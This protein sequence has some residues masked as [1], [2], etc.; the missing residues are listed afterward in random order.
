MRFFC[1]L[2][3]EVKKYLGASGKIPSGGN[4]KAFNE[5]WVPGESS[6]KEITAAVCS[7]SGLCAWHLIDGRR[8]KNDTGAIK[9]GL[10]IIDVDNQDDK[11]DSDGEK[12]QRQE[13]TP[14]ES[15]TLDLSKKYLSLGYFSPSSTATWPRFRLVFGLE[16]PIIDPEFFQ[17]FTRFIAEQIPGSDRRATQIVNL[18]YGANPDEKNSI[19]YLSENFIPAAKIDEAYLAYLAAPKQVK[20]NEDAEDFIKIPVDENG[21]DISRLVSSTV[22]GILNGE[23]VEDRSFAMA[24]AFKEVI[25]WCNWLNEQNIAVRQ[26]PLTMCRLIFENIYEYSSE[27]DGKFNR[28][29]SSI[30]DA[31]TLRPAIALAS[32]DGETALWKKLKYQNK[33]LFKDKCPDSIKEQIQI[34]KPAP[35]NSVLNINDLTTST[36]NS[37]STPSMTQTTPASPAQLINLQQ[38]NRQFSENDIA[39]VIVNNYGDSFLYDSTLDEFF[40]YDS[41]EGIWYIQ[42]EQHIKRRIVKTLD[43]FVAAGVLPRYNAATVSS[44]FQLLKAKLLRSLNNGRTAIWQKSS[45][46]IPFEN[47]VLVSETQKFIEGNQQ[48]LYFRT[49]LHYPYDVKAS[50]PLFLAWLDSSVG[51]DK[52]ILIRA[53][54]RA[55]LTSYTTGERFLHLVGPGGTGKSTMQQILIA[56]AGFAGTHTSSL[57]II[58]TNKFECHNLIGKKLLLLTD[59]SNFNKRLDVLKKITSASD[60]LRAERKYGKEVINFKPELLVCIASNEHISSSDISSGL[61]RR[62]LTILMDKVVPP[63]QRRD[64]LNV[65]ADH[66]DGD[67][68]PELSGIVTWALSMP[69][70]EMRDVLAN[71]VKHVPTL[72]ATNL[73]ALIFNNPYVAW[74]AE[75]T[76]YAP[77]QSSII[78]GGAFRPSTDESERGLFVKNAYSEL[79]ASYVNFCKSN[80]YKHSAKPRFVDRLKETIKNV[81]RVPGVEPRFIN[82]KA[83]FVGLRLKPYDVTTDRASSGED[84]L[85]S[86]VEFASNPSHDFWKISFNKHDPIPA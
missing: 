65:Y 11:K 12:V 74:L 3:S 38:E 57:E 7:A 60:T 23:A 22:Q 72:N 26:D 19:F 61:E 16:K 5:N 67:F 1:S 59:E 17:W 58:E 13:L 83:T 48:D 53:F 28:I 51:A 79:Y 25:G 42:D 56:L 66:V 47:G 50:C 86:P 71:P 80:G 77:N 8:S 69:F 63:S 9:A 52:A 82:G 46:Y 24:M 27:L 75:C 21:V 32:E 34:K 49:K 55:L 35:K 76:L 40:T 68:V 78:G 73:E 15:I 64:L 30:T 39:E 2:N 33:D 37:N 54:C 29:L 18:F 44:V 31:A 4:F 62:R 14:T 43:T 6:I 10:I 45:G 85:P 20:T 81:L 36:S 70:D 41:D 84:R